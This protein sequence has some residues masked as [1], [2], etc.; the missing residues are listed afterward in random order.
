MISEKKNYKKAV[1]FSYDDGI[2]QDR[3][4]VELFNYYGMKCTFNLN[5]GI[6]TPGSNFEIEG[7]K[8]HRMPQEGLDK[9]YAGHEIAVHGLTHAAPTTLSELG[10][11][12]E[13]L[14]DAKNI[15]KLYGRYPT[16]MAYAYGV[17]TEEAAEYLSKIGI[18]YARTVSSTHRFDLPKD[19]M[20]LEA[21]CHHQDDKLFELAEEFLHTDAAEDKP[22]LFYIW[23]HSY[24]FDVNK[25]WERM[26]KLCDMLA[27]REDIFYGTNSEC[28]LGNCSASV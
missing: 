4:L 11:E 1:T 8:I 6:Q 22:M 16:G 14:Q 27:G 9:L 26:E 2:E 28:L 20:H 15:E 19:F 25:N 23:G 17:V 18:R 3:R 12:G 10:L 7:V 21:T 5:T 24:E 13:F